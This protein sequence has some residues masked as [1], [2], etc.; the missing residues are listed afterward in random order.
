MH[1]DAP[2]TSFAD[3]FADLVLDRLSAD[4]VSARAT[5]RLVSARGSGGDSYLVDVQLPNGTAV[6][7]EVADSVPTV[8]V[9]DPNAD[10]LR[11]DLA[12]TYVV[13][14]ARGISARRAHE[15]VHLPVPRASVEM[16]NLCRVCGWDLEEPPW[17]GRE[18]RYLI[19]DC[20]G[21]E[22]GVDDLG[23]RA[24]RRWLRRWLTQ[25]TPW[26]DET[27]RPVDWD[28]HAQLHAARID[29]A[30]N[31]GCRLVRED[32]RGGDDGDGPVGVG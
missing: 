18:P 29:V 23:E 16:P 10:D 31:A 15:T 5:L 2:G 25:G 14:R 32:H 13:L 26:F 30:C 22:S 9:M 19:C 28:V 3:R 12:V 20:C 8:R 6:L 21:A 7:C 1:D 17:S 11:L 4:G 27:A 24:A